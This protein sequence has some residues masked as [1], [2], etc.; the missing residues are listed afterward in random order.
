MFLFNKK[1]NEKKADEKKVKEKVT[2]KKTH[3][4][5]LGIANTAT[6]AEIKKAYFNLVRIY[7]PDRSPKEFKEIRAAYETLSDAEK[8]AEYDAI[9]DLPPSIVPLFH[10]AQRFDRFGRPDK[11]VKLYQA[12][13]TIHPELDH[14]RE[15][16]ALSLAWD[17]KTGKAIEVWEELCRRQPDNPRY[18]RGLGRCY[19][20]RGWHK[21]AMTEARRAVSLE[22]PSIES[23]SLLVSCALEGLKNDGDTWDELAAISAE[24]V[25]AVKPVTTNEWEKIHLYT[26]AFLSAGSR[27]R[28]DAKR[29]LREMIRLIRENGMRGRESGQQ[30]MSEMLKYVP[31]EGLALHYPELKEMADLL[32]D[33]SGSLREKLDAARLGSDIERL[34]GK[35]FHDVFYDLFRILND[36]GMTSDDDLELISIEY[37]I[38]DN[39]QTFDPQL[40]RLKV[41]FPELYA[42]HAPFF[43][44]VLRTRDPEKMLYQRGKKIK[45]LR[46]LT[47]V[48]EDDD[49]PDSGPAVTVHRAQPKVGRNDPCPCGSGKKY[50]HCCGA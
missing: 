5:I 46:R 37:Y 9:G 49:E 4:E 44:M 48:E 45:K 12:I 13:L 8:R 10:E 15:E 47:N 3:Y 36:D 2:V 35:K 30:A 39:K 16:C 6:N 20:E 17:K 23:W 1:V 14:V 25:K 31:V 21:K 28:N 41:E 42:L 29:Y 27:N 22:R 38:L 32:P 33:L 11:A 19:L 34:Q 24:A 26:H 40:R 43:N 50:K 7:Q 18:A